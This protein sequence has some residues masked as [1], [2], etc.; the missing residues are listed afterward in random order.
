MTRRDYLEPSHDATAKAREDAVKQNRSAALARQAH[1]D[2][3][4][5]RNPQVSKLTLAP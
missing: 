4:L 5:S 2:P 1:I 3:G